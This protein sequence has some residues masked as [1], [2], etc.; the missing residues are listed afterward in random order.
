[1]RSV[2]RRRKAGHSGPRLFEL[3]RN[4]AMALICDLKTTADCDIV[5]VSGDIFAG[6]GAVLRK[7]APK[8]KRK[9][10]VFDLANL[11]HMNSVG[12]LEWSVEFAKIL[13]S[14]LVELINCPIGFTGY[15]QIIP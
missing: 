7:L 9:R 12:C 5:A 3:E 8:L 4:A 1:M 13:S 2:R 15:C 10:V 11:R 14:N 6:S